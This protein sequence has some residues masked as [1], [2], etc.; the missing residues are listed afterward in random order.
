MYQENIEYRVGD[1]IFV[2]YFCCDTSR[3]GKRPLVLVAHD[4]SGRSEVVCDKARKLAELGY[5]GFAVDMYGGGKTGSSN[6]EK[7][8]L[9]QPLIDDRSMLRERIVA[10]LAAARQ[11]DKVDAARVAAI[12]YCFGGLVALDLARSGADVKGVVSFHGALIK[13]EKLDSK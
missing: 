1:Q 3:E 7:S 6:D 13:P 8:A 11:F 4:W 10:A 9:M 2:G 12:G 5:A